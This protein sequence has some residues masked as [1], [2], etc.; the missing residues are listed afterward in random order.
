MWN[1]NANS[2]N[3]TYLEIPGLADCC[4]SH[5]PQMAI[6]VAVAIAIAIERGNRQ[7]QKQQQGISH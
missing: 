4:I 1:K 2:R 7:R 6:T 5:L 3:T